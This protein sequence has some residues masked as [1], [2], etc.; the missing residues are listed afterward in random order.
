MSAA[1]EDTADTQQRLLAMIQAMLAELRGPA[2]A[3]VSIDADLERDLGI[4]SLA[5]AELL[6][7]IESA[8]GVRLPEEAAFTA[9]TPRVLLRL[10]NDARGTGA[11]APPAAPMPVRVASATAEAE[12]LDEPRHCT[13]L[14][15]VLEWHAARH[16]DR[17]H[18]TLLESDDAPLELRYGELAR[19]ARRVAG[20]LHARGLQPGRAGAIKLP[21]GFAFL[22]VLYGVL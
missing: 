5:R 12:A 17:V 1:I 11:V 8:F 4:D 3:T 9:P 18:V 7:R 10:I 15:D 22:S 21:A 6:L 19:E 2:G 16:P 20:A 13:H 14:I